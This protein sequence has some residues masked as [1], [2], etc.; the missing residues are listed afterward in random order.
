VKVADPGKLLLLLV[1]MIGGLVLAIVGA[2]THDAG[3]LASGVGLAGT[4]L[5]YVTGNGRLASRGAAPQ[6]TLGPRNPSAA[7]LDAL[8]QLGAADYGDSDT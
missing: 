2:L 7:Q 3:V 1:A 8:D 5:G 4:S 6:P